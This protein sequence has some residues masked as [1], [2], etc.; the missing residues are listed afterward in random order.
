[1][2]TEKKSCHAGFC[3]HAEPKISAG[4]SRVTRPAEL[5]EMVQ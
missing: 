2:A 1:M 4:A 3:S 5:K